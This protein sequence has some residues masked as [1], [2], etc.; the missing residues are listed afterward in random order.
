MSNSSC[1]TRSL[2]TIQ[3]RCGRGRVIPQ[4]DHSAT[5][6]H[7]RPVAAGFLVAVVVVSLLGIQQAPGVEVLQHLVLCRAW[8]VPEDRRRRCVRV[9]PG[10]AKRGARPSALHLCYA[11]STVGSEKG[12]ES[13]R[14]TW[15]ATGATDAS[16][17]LRE[18]PHKSRSARRAFSV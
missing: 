14:P 7:P 9:A 2:P 13:K 17:G 12:H 6:R 18:M 8:H 5:T 3:K 11:R 1:R 15:P 16:V 4:C 10:G